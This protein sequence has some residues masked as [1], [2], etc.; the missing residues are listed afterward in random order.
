MIKHQSTFFHRIKS[1][2]TQTLLLKTCDLNR[3]FCI[4]T[5]V[6]TQSNLCLFFYHLN[7][8][9]YFQNRVLNFKFVHLHRHVVGGYVG[10]SLRFLRNLMRQRER[11]TLALMSQL[12]IPLWTFGR[13]SAR[14]TVVPLSTRNRSTG[15]AK[16]IV[17][18]HMWQRGGLGGTKTVEAFGPSS[19]D[20]DGAAWDCCLPPQL[21]G[22]FLPPRSSIEI[23]SS[24]MELP[25]GDEVMLFNDQLVSVWGISSS[26]RLK[27]L[28]SSAWAQVRKTELDSWT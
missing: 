9:N 28:A 23:P 25:E 15:G 14:H 12:Q 13:V 6:C 1:S 18:L 17:R 24:H 16:A 7:L 3:C 27:N 21:R 10:F 22:E 11:V 26:R 20:L 4:P 19:I 8:T 2:L 5:M